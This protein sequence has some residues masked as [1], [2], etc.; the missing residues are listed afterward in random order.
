MNGYTCQRWDSQSPQ[1]HQYYPSKYPNILVENYCRN[2]DGIYAP[3]CYTTN[4]SI[5]WEFCSIPPCV[6][7][8]SRVVKVKLIKPSSVDLNDPAVLQ[9]LL[10]QL[11]QKLQDQGVKVNRV[12][13]RKKQD[14]Q[15]FCGEEKTD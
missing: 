15:I 12:M 6:P 5:R 11:Q 1:T 2:P 9:D 8:L 7:V 3:W 14:G 13:W 4:S 10:K